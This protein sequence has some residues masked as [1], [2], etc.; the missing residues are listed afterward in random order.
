MNR[1]DLREAVCELAQSVSADVVVLC[2]CGASAGDV[3]SILRSH[4]DAKFFMPPENYAFVMPTD[5]RESR[6]QCFSRV[7]GL[8]L[9]EAYRGRRISIRHWKTVNDDRLMAFVHG[10]DVRNHGDAV[11]QS[12]MQELCRDIQYYVSL[13]GTSRLAL[14]GD[15]N[16]NPFDA[17]LNLAAGMNAMMTRA[18]TSRG[19]RVLGGKPYDF[20]YNP[21]WSLFG[22]GTPG[23]AGTIYNRSSQGT[24]GWSMFDQVIVHHSLI[25]AFEKVE[26]LTETGRRPLKNSSG[27]PD[28]KKFSDHFPILATFVN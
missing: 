3:L 7:A 15:F 2:E 11:R 23:P 25:P 4:V 24:Y 6:F 12:K 28:K 10:V 13:L 20:Y 26:I 8:D 17:A 19:A 14:I 9:S 21:M 5:N 27:R 22:D 1:K 18:C 16:M